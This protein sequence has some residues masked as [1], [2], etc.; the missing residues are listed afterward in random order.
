MDDKT[1][2]VVAGAVLTG[3]AVVSLAIGTGMANADLAGTAVHGMGAG[4][5]NGEPADGS[6]PLSVPAAPKVA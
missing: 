5:N 1:R 6:G 3:A 4:S 2:R